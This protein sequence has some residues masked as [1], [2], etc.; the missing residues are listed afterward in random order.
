MFFR[1]PP[2]ATYQCFHTEL[3]PYCNIGFLAD[4]ITP[5]AGRVPQCVRSAQSRAQS[6]SRRLCFTPF[7][8]TTR[9]YRNYSSVQCKNIRDISDAR[10]KRALT[11]SAQWETVQ[12][13]T[14]RPG[15]SSSRTDRRRGVPRSTVE[16]DSVPPTAH[17]V[18]DERAREEILKY[19]GN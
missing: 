8:R 1:V 15:L 17:L 7:S 2:D 10:P 5:V 3:I 14:R 16:L 9:N 13:A 6:E 11:D 19:H 18:L 12:A 4:I